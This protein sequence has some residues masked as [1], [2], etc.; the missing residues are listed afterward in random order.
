MFILFPCCWSSRVFAQQKNISESVAYIDTKAAIV[1]ESNI[2]E[3]KL[4]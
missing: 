4:G 1:G 3:D 2:I